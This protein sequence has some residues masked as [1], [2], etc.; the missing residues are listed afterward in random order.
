MYLL[1]KNKYD[2]INEFKQKSFKNLPKQK[3]KQHLFNVSN[4]PLN[5]ILPKK[6]LNDNL[7]LQKIITANKSPLKSIQTSSR[8]S[9][10]P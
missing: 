3:I 8:K 5:N 7:K 9:V 4:K 6:P 2:K 1:H 10:K